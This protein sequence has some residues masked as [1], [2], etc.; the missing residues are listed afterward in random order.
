M[1]QWTIALSPYSLLLQEN[2]KICTSIVFKCLFFNVSDAKTAKEC[3]KC[4][5]RREWEMWRL[6]EYSEVQ[7]IVFYKFIFYLILTWTILYKAPVFSSTVFFKPHL[8]L[9]SLSKEPHNYFFFFYSRFSHFVRCPWSIKTNP[10]VFFYWDNLVL[11]I[12]CTLH[13]LNFVTISLTFLHLH[14][15]SSFNEYPV[16]L[17]IFHILSAHVKSSFL[18]M[19]LHIICGWCV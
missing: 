4:A 8:W 6:W 5:F 1:Y 18:C 3:P 14:V 9:I 12:Y 7:G 16:S 10:N 2:R 11:M 15:F 19:N 13:T 17:N